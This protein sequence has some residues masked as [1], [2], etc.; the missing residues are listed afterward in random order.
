VPSDCATNERETA[1]SGPRTALEPV[2]NVHPR[3]LSA[4][5]RHREAITALPRALEL[6][7]GLDAARAKRDAAITALQQ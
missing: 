3:A 6:E 7:P 2:A 5:Q 1:T 4:Q